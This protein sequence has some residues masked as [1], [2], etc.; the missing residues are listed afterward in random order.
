MPKIYLTA[1]NAFIWGVEQAMRRARVKVLLVPGNHDHTTAFY[2]AHA[3]SVWFRNCDRV[4]VD[5]AP[6]TRKYIRYGECLVGYTHGNEE[7]ANRLPG[8]MAQEQR[9]AWGETEHH[10]F[11]KGHVHQSKTEIATTGNTVDGMVI[12]TLRSLSGRDSWH[13]RKGYGGP[14]AAE[15]FLM[16][17][18]EGFRGMF[19]VNVRLD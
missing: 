9:Q 16:S 10:E 3:V 11:R 7:P 4:E 17:K 5:C 19:N 8:I 2:L 6:S 13:A 15:C 18:T 1:F 14:R 12:R